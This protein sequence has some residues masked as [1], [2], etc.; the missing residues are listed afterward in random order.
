[1]V[2]SHVPLTLTVPTIKRCLTLKVTMMY[3]LILPL[4]IDR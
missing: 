4:E 2:Y 3:N 1:M